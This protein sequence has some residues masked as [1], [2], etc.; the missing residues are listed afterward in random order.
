M[1]R[2]R[3]TASEL[4]FSYRNAEPMIEMG[5]RNHLSKTQPNR[6]TQKTFSPVTL[7]DGVRNNQQTSKTV[8][9]PPPS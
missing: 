9:L 4:E 5:T 1:R 2:Q 3:A 8:L 6:Y 7:L